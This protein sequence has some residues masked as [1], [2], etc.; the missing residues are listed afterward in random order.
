MAMSTIKQV[1]MEELGSLDDVVF[2]DVREKDEFDLGAIP[3]ALHLPLSRIAINPKEAAEKL[4]KDKNC[5]LYC[6]HG[7]RSLQATDIFMQM[8]CENVTSLNGGYAFWC[9]CQ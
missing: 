3:G 1:S 7:M 9:Q 5:I 6:A 2:I 4:P 8:G